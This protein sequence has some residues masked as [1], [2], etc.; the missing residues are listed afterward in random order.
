MGK[1]VSIERRRRERI[2]AEKGAVAFSGSQHGQVIDASLRGL[3]FQYHSSTNQ[4]VGRDVQ[5]GMGEGTLDIVF[6]A[7][8]FNLVGLPVQ[9]V[10]DFQIAGRQTSGGRL[11][12]RRRVVIFGQLTAE[13]LFSLKRFL[14]L[15]QYGAMPPA[16]KPGEKEESSRP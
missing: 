2:S 15:K 4:V 16:G 13:Q 12:I 10:A 3:S 5:K 9:T 1:K 8:N 7:Y 11:R 6:G 14:L